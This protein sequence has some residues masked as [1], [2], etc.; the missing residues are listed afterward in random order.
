MQCY[1]GHGGIENAVADGTDVVITGRAADSALFLV[2]LAY[3]FGWADNDWD[4][5]ARG[6][7]AGHL[8]ECGG[9]GFGELSDTLKLC[10]GYHKGWKTVSMLSFAWQDAYEKASIVQVS[11]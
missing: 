8:L 4:N 11:L 3:E 7:M 10:V 6:I 9:Q 5:L 1:I 2:P